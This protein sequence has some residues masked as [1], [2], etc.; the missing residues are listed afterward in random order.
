MFY[1]AVSLGIRYSK[2]WNKLVVS[3]PRVDYIKNISLHE[4]VF[5]SLFRNVAKNLPGDNTSQLI[6]K[7]IESTNL[8][9]H[10]IGAP[11]GTHESEATEAQDITGILG[12]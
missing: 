12:N 6:S 4:D 11:R 10:W 1:D 5:A 7:D 2:F 8:I 3:Y 9:Q